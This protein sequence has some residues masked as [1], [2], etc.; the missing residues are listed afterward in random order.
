MWTPERQPPVHALH[1]HVD[2]AAHSVRQNASEKDSVSLSG[3]EPASHDFMLA[4]R[5]QLQGSDSMRGQ[6]QSTLTSQLHNLHATLRHQARCTCPCATCLAFALL[7][8]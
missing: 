3:S 7:T 2:L 8:L 5:G 4:L 1:A 6:G